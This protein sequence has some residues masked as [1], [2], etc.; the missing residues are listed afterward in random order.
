MLMTV[1]GS[2]HAPETTRRGYAVEDIRQRVRLQ[3]WIC[4]STQNTGASAS[5]ARSSVFEAATG[6]VSS[7]FT[8]AP[9]PARAHSSPAAVALRILCGLACWRFGCFCFF[10]FGRARDGLPLPASA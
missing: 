9:Q 10:L 1:A 2:S 8:A 7:D 5:I 4:S 6:I 3:P